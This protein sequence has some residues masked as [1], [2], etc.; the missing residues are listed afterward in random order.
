MINWRD[1]EAAKEYRHEMKREA[2][3]WRLAR[4]LSPRHQRSVRIFLRTLAWLGYKLLAVG[5]QW[6]N[7][8]GENRRHGVRV[9]SARVTRCPSAEALTRVGRYIVSGA[10]QN[11]PSD[12]IS[13]QED[14]CGRLCA[15]LGSLD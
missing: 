7:R 5:I 10:S 9:S 8:Y 3:N 12:L 2:A 11:S 1:V 13:Y 4:Q 15:R 14:R 6:L